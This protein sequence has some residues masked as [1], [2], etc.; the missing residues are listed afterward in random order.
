MSSSGAYVTTPKPTTSFEM[1]IM[2]CPPPPRRATMLV[3]DLA[4]SEFTLNLVHDSD[5][6]LAAPSSPSSNPP[7]EEDDD[8][9]EDMLKSCIRMPVML[10]PRRRRPLSSTSGPIMDL[11]HIKLQPRPKTQVADVSMK[12]N[13]AAGGAASIK[14]PMNKKQKMMH[15]S[16]SFSSP[17]A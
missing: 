7:Q 13:P 9:D 10:T 16:P 6:F 17:A 4:P 12:M 14:L 5:F 11:P 3:D 8:G 15:R 1:A 2:A